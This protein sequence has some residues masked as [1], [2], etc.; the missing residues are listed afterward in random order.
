MHI[1]YSLILL[2][3]LMS[4]CSVGPAYVAPPIAVPSEWKNTQQQIDKEIDY[5]DQWWQVFE[6][7]KLDE[8][9]T[10]AV[11]NNRDLL[12]SW[13]RIHEARALMGI[14]AADFYPQVNLNPLFTNT[15][16]LIKTYA[17]STNN[18]ISSK[19]VFRAHE[20]FYFM[21]VNLSYEVDLWGK[22]RD[23][24]DSTRYNW[25]AKKS[26]YEATLLSLTSALAIAYYQ[27]RTAD[28][29]MDLLLRTIQIRQKALDINQDR[30]DEEIVNY[31][32]VS[33]AA[34][35]LDSVIA[36]YEEVVRQRA[37]LEDQIAVL[38][39]V[40]A[41]EFC[42]E[43]FPL[44]G[45]PPNIP[46]GIPSEVLLRRPDIA[47]AEYN[48][49]SEHA[50]IKEAVSLLFPSLTL[51]ATAGSESPVLRYFLKGFS[52]YWM[53][54][55]GVNQIIFD[56]GRSAYN[57]ELQISRF[58]QASAAYQNQVLIAFQEVED[59]LA[60][61]NSYASQYEAIGETTQWAM[62]SYQLYSDRYTSGVTYY[63]DVVNTEQSLL[64]YQISLNALQGFRY[65]AT[66]QLIKALGGGW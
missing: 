28:E 34:Q 64:N 48:A 51:T 5:P 18:A 36:Q 3:A 54:G 30:Y 66:V 2:L 39:G 26:D 16:E 53:N 21:P 31:S 32:D 20:L 65:I 37:V 7:D 61:L 59:A 35:E 41:S 15:D 4:S 49:K 55:L 24:Y 13:E 47:E 6:D 52:R 43:H 44:R 11:A 29:Q 57:L 9:E 23:R 12:I 14:A 38:I 25:L 22:I 50:L 19:N 1:Y 27:L 45:L 40:P 10:L 62:K 60:D 33:L 8:L 17:N 56:G 63:I 46:E 58:E 42:V